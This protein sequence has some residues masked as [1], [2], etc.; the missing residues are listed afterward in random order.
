MF[1]LYD[2]NHT[3]DFHDVNMKNYLNWTYI[4]NTVRKN[5]DY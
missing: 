3:P 2:Q 5:N 1:V 4:C